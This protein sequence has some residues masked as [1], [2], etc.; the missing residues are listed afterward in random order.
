M[1]YY[2]HNIIIMYLVKM[3]WNFFQRMEKKSSHRRQIWLQNHYCHFRLRSHAR[4]NI[5]IMSI[6]L[7]PARTR[8]D[9]IDVLLKTKKTEHTI[10]MT[11]QYN[12]CSICSII[13]RWD[14]ILL[15]ISFNMFIF[16][17]AFCHKIHMTTFYGR[18]VILF[19]IIKSKNLKVVILRPTYFFFIN[20]KT[21]WNL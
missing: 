16:K 8:M 10:T 21:N 11:P 20:F 15:N 5:D 12:I 13:S 18:I 14:Y 9:I 7:V 6:K 4:R 19:P 3:F 2:Q 1:N 17:Y